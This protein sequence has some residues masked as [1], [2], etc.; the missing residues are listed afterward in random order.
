ML[1]VQ[2]DDI[3][4]HLNEHSLNFINFINDN[5]KDIYKGT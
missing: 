5:Y 4:K 1:T 3:N 2:P